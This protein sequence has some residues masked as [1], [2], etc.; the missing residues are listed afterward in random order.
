MMNI[1]IHISEN[2]TVD[3][4]TYG[5]ANCDKYLIYAHGFKGFKDWG[6][7][8]YLAEFF[9]SSG[10]FV[11]TFNFSHNG[12]G[13][14]GMDFNELDKFAKNTFSLEISE[15]N[16]I[17]SKTAQGE[18]GH[19]PQKLYLLGHSRGGADVLLSAFNNK[20]VDGVIT[21]ASIAK[22]DRYSGRQKKE[23]KEKGFWEIQNARTKQTMRLDYSLLKDI[24]DNA[25]GHLNLENAVKKL[26]LPLLIIHGE[27]DLAVPVSEGKQLFEWADKSLTEFVVI[28]QTGH[29][30]GAVH[31]FEKTN[32]QLEAILQKSLNFLNNL[33]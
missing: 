4:T 28:P 2:I 18:F 31:P 5:D 13:Q 24:Q 9:S 23:W 8:P 12:V 3:V 32:D 19:I 11:I 7:V 20:N 15:L 30:F 29:T 16:E 26:N 6:F 33:S 1:K 17:I 25:K 22:L 10:F 21:W 27:Q 14:G